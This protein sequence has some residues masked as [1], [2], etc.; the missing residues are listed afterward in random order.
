MERT[1][2]GARAIADALVAAEGEVGATVV[3]GGTDVHQL[4]VDLAPSGREGAIVLGQLNAL[5]ISANAIRLAFDKAPAGGASGLRFGAT[6]LAARG[7]SAG[8]FDEVGR[9]LVAAL[10]D[11]DQRRAAETAARVAELLR[12]RPLYGFID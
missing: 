11:R 10:A 4:L 6:A 7:F 9:V 1:L 8:D 3:T 2:A 12:G 5:G